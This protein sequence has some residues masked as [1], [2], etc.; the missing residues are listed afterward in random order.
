MTCALASK[1]VTY[2]SYVDGVLTLTFSGY[3]KRYQGVP[4][5]VGYGL[6]YSPNPLG[7]F[8]TNIKNQFKSVKL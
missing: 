3:T 8:N 1:V 2:M 5:A 7:Y 4:Q 6:C